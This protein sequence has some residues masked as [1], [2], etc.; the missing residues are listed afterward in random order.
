[1]PLFVYVCKAQDGLDNDHKL[2]EMLATCEPMPTTEWLS[3]LESPENGSL[4]C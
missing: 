2:F 4:Y 3:W 1:M